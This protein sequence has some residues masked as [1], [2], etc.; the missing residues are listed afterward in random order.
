M[1]LKRDVEL[2]YLEIHKI[3][4]I[5]RI[6]KRILHR[7]YGGK[8]RRREAHY[9]IFI[10]IICGLMTFTHFYISSIK[11][12]SFSWLGILCGCASRMLVEAAMGK[13]QLHC[14]A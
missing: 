1:Q 7:K 14:N 5:W 9:H 6:E 12:F 11:M 8:Y 13:F 2:I 4:E 10:K 3:M